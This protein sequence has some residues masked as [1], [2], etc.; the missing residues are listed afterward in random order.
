MTDLLERRGDVGPPEDGLDAFTDEHNQADY[1]PDFYGAPIAAGPEIETVDVRASRLDDGTFRRQVPTGRQVE[2][3]AVPVLDDLPRHQVRE[4]EPEVTA[5]RPGAGRRALDFLGS[6][7]PL[8]IPGPKAPMLVLGLSTLVAG[9]DNLALQLI[10]PELRGEFGTSITLLAT[11]GSITG[12]FTIVLGLPMGYLFDRVKRI[13]LVRV[14]FIGRNVASL[15]MAMAPTFPLFVGGRLVGTAAGVVDGP[16]VGPLVADWYPSR[17]RAR[18]FAYLAFTGQ[19]GGLIGLPIA[20]FMIARFGWRSAVATLALV[21][22]GVSLLSFLLREPVRG[23][24]DRLEMGATRETAAR[25]QPPPSFQESIRAGW[26]IRTLRVMAYGSVV[27]MFAGPVGL[28]LSIIQAERF[29]LDPSQRAMLQ[30]ISALCTLPAFIVGGA[31]TDR[32][33]AKKPSTIVVIQASLMFASSLGAL[34][35]AFAPTLPLFILPTIVVSFASSAISPSVTVVTTLIIPARYRATAGQIMT[36][37]QLV[38]LLLGPVITSFAERLPVQQGLLM[39]APFYL[40]SGLVMLAA[41]STIERDIRAARAASLAFRESEVAAAA[42]AGK[43]LVCRDLDVAYDQVQILFNVDLDVQEGECLALLGTNG[44][45]KST[46]LRAIAGVVEAENGAIVFDGRDITHV[47][48]HENARHGIVLM[49]G[50]QA[51]FPTM[52]VQENLSA[53]AWTQRGDKAAV[54]AGIQ[55]IL[56]MFPVLRDRLDIQA[57]AMS[58]G[59]Q[60][61]LAL[62]QAF[63]MRPRLLMID[64]LSLGLAPAVVE[65]LLGVLRRIRE[66]GTAVLLVEQS[67]NVALTVAERALFMEKGEIQMDGPIEE[68]LRRPDLVR[69]IFMGGAVGGGRT[70]RRRAPVASGTEEERPILAAEEIS[71][72]FGGIRAL[73]DVEVAVAAG[74]VV[75]IIGPNG[76]GKTTLFDVLSG[77]LAPD[78]GRV[79]LAGEDIGTLSPDA[80]ARLGLGRAF[81]NARLF[82]PLT[83]RENIAVALERRA[84]KNPLLAALW[85]PRARKSERMIATRV[86]GFIELLGLT[87]YADKFVRELSTGTR[88]AVEVACIMAAEPKV[89]LLDEPSSGLAQ[90]ET[91]ALGPA[92]ARVVRDTGCGLLVIEHDLPLITS[93]SDRLVAMELGSVLLTGPPE[94]VT[95][96]PRVLESYLAASHDVIER[97]GSRVGTVLG[98]I[99]SGDDGGAPS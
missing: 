28:Y 24:M 56:E 39:F 22:T 2:E 29:Q 35:G 77:Y 26:A 17:A 19:V 82:P 79:L 96:H 47:P 99:A 38:G 18:V 36:P 74:E 78:G 55:E 15:L 68:L 46:L 11:I 30:T 90:A 52:T 88:R 6:I 25:T 45:G 94:E 76:A 91:E 42:G 80:R 73:S 59:E 23:G 60:Q 41:A 58:G 72:S 5:A 8:A 92:L 83:V 4:E 20:G 89:L 50:G 84:V 70:V 98:L 65:Q 71:V 97:S 64:E 85:T 66:S 43:L 7:N 57:G 61:M 48:A 44:A 62:G 75:G 1:L 12:F 40:A 33:L 67:L 34:W 27:T 51:V 14:G 95:R 63:L 9:W 81:Q 3:G 87:A 54:E 37:F 86:D 16:G 10:G 31:I 69:S 53:A 32:L 49:P 21:A 13:R 93:I